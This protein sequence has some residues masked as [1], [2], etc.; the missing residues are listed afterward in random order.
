LLRF[1]VFFLLVVADLIQHRMKENFSKDYFVVFC[2]V[3]L[4]FFTGQFQGRKSGKL[5]K[6]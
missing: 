4:I 3:F 1:F 2:F 5:K 6:S